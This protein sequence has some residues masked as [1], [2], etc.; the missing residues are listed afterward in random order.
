MV[1]PD[2]PSGLREY[3]ERFIAAVEKGRQEAARGDLLEHD[4]V[5]ARIER[6]LQ[7]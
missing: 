4:E 7:G 6:L 2:D 1:I 5:V 3:D